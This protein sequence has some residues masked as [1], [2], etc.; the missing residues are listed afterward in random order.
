MKF[1]RSS[2]GRWFL[3]LSIVPIVI[4]SVIMILLSSNV[5]YR[6][7]IKDTKDLLRGCA[8]ELVY[9]Y[10]ILAQGGDGIRR[11]SNGKFYTGDIQISGDYSVVDRI[12]EHANVEVTL[13]YEDTRVVTTL[14]DENNERLVGSRATE[15]WKDTVSQGKDYFDESVTI[16]D[17]D[18]FGYYVPVHSK[19][20]KVIGMG[21]A[22]IPSEDIHDT[23]SYLSR[24][25]LIVG[26]VLCFFV[27]AL[28]IW[29]TGHL[30][31]LQGDLISYLNEIDAGKYGHA[32]DE[33]LYNRKDEYGIM[34]R[35]FVNLNDSLQKLILLDGL[36]N[37]YNRRAAM[38]YLEQYVVDANQ[39]EA[40]PFTFCICDIDFFK[41]VNDTYGHGCGDLVLKKVADVLN[42]IPREEGFSARWGGEEFIVV[43]KKRKNEALETIEKIAD[44][45]REI[46]VEYD[47]KEISVTMT[48]GVTEY[49]VPEKLD[50]LISRA[51]AFLY[52]GKEDGRNRIVS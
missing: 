47:G 10:E 21:F 29:V 31:K 19:D 22:G 38:K 2:V 35:H 4:I 32:M 11:E 30:L 45:I 40:K 14:V 16:R 3:G 34:G 44:E 17:K 27:V 39:W 15:I 1:Y 42:S 37:L 7:K 9:T 23:I 41:H 33:K 43:L 28:S 20:G 25:S 8:K 36:T 6:T 46:V 12:K 48:F 50:L 52:K 49:I 26:L 13:F 24:T 18:Y 51:D 5:V